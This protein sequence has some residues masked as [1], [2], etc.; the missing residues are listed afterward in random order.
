[1]VM[2]ISRDQM[3]ME[4]ARTASKRSTCHR[5][6]VGALLVHGNNVL[7]VG[8][9]GPPSG[10]PHCKGNDCPLNDK[11]GCVSADHAEKN[12]IERAPVMPKDND[13][14]FLY[15]TDSP[16]RACAELIGK[17]GIHCVVY[18]KPYRDITPVDDILIK[19][20]DIAVYRLTPSGYLMNHETG[21]V[22][23]ENR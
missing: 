14:I 20:Y 19:K 4:M 6:S 23:H 7:S 10:Q 22:Y 1:M 5:L 3:W 18:E 9:N 16:C 8:Y 11:G 21:Q 15:V 17:A 2:R 13:A 12:A